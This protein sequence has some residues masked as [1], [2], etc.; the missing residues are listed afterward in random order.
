MKRLLTLGGNHRLTA[1]QAYPPLKAPCCSLLE[2][3][4]QIIA[5]APVEP[6]AAKGELVLIALDKLE[7]TASLIQPQRSS[8][9][10]SGRSECM[11]KTIHEPDTHGVL[12]SAQALFLKSG[13]CSSGRTA[14]RPREGQG[15]EKDEGLER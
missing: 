10:T 15:A 13:I 5:A 4:C 3:F 2:K 9:R 8:K 11:N 7:E 14:A 6:V 12:P 1:V